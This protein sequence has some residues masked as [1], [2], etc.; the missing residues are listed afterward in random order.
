MPKHIARLPTV[1]GM[2]I[3]YTTTFT[4]HDP[5]LPGNP[6]YTGYDDTGS[7]IE[8]CRCEFGVGR[9]EFGKPC[10]HR[11]RKA[12]LERR[13]VTCGRIIGAKSELIFI[14]VAVHEHETD[15]AYSI[16]PPAHPDCAGYSVLVCPR[17]IEKADD[18]IVARCRSYELAQLVAVPGPD[19][20]PSHRLAPLGEPVRFGIID[21]F[22][23]FPDPATA[24]LM[25][26]REW[27]RHHAPRQ[28]RVA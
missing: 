17:L 10:P 8:K 9:P 13:C 19:G 4:N 14:G 24:T 18:V 7:L 28:Y 27:L 3:P 22:G 15:V 25:P 6:Y 1:G 2:P 5:S 21:L 16:E 12:M 26:L 11:Q 23:A 20:K